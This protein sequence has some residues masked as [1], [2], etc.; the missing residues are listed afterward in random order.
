MKSAEFEDNN[1]TLELAIAPKIRYH[2]ENAAIKSHHFRSFTAK[3]D[4]I[5][6]NIDKVEQADALTKPLPS[7]IF[8]YLQK[9]LMGF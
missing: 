5:I 1:G 6:K 4:I 7:Q 8:C 9:K 3:G 2:T